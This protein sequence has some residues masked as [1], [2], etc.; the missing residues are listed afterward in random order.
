MAST[1]TT[2]RVSW[3][4]DEFRASL[5]RTLSPEQQARMS[6]L[7]TEPLYLLSSPEPAV[8]GLAWDERR[9]TEADHDSEHWRVFNTPVA[10]FRISGSTGTPHAVS[11]M[12]SGR[13][14]CSC[15][16]ARVHARKTA[17]A[18]KHVSFV[19]VRAMG[20]TDL[21]FFAVGLRLSSD[22]VRSCVDAAA[23]R[24]G[25]DVTSMTRPAEREEEENEDEDDEEEEGEEE[26]EEEEDDEE[27]EEEEDDI[28]ASPHHR[29]GRRSGSESYYYYY[30]ELGRRVRILRR[31][32]GE[33]RQTEARGAPDFVTP[34][35][36]LVPE[37]DECPVCYATL[38]DDGSVW[39]DEAKRCIRWCP[40]CRNAIHRD[41]VERW[42]TT[43]PFPS[44]VLCRSGVWDAWDHR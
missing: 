39:A 16:D 5:R 17:C 1:P 13:V 40:D 32:R 29:D 14:Q 26:E 30:A 12:R 10:C 35:K 28:D 19:L 8:S 43:S 2:T 38:L 24:S 33:A 25:V 27:E 11:V 15:P 23:R 31:T 42:L 20:F 44:C 3:R 36:D 9:R 37:S 4:S 34:G 18:C 7:Y 22:E 21:R 6:R 41:C